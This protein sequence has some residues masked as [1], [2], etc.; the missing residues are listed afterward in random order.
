ME[1]IYHLLAISGQLWNRWYLVL[2]FTVLVQYNK[3]RAS[4]SQ[5][6]GRSFME[7][8]V[9]RS[10]PTNA[11]AGMWKRSAW[12]Q[13]LHQRGISRNMKHIRL[14]QVRIRQNPIWL[15]NTEE[16]SPEVQNRGICGPTK[17]DSCPPKIIKKTKKQIQFL[18]CWEA[19]SKEGC[20]VPMWVERGIWSL[21]PFRLEIQP[22]RF[23][24]QVYAH[25]F[26]HSPSSSSDW[27]MLYALDVSMKF[28][29]SSTNLSRILIL[30]SALVFDSA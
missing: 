10:T 16:T 28:P 9:S 24:K 2:F 7:R 12:Q 27:P 14:C 30:V 18:D 11:F 25:I 4:I 22:E 26:I 15:W 20:R 6:V 13:I 3:C 8:E 29:P 23:W 1:R 17:K 21:A 5:S 19:Q